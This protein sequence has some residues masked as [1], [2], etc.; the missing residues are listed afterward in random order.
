MKFSQVVLY[1]KLS[2]DYYKVFKLKLKT[3]KQLKKKQKLA[4]KK[5]TLLNQGLHWVDTITDYTM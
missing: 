4:F 3:K 1:E 5:K 2:T